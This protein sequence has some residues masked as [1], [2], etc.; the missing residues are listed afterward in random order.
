MGSESTPPRALDRTLF[1]IARLAYA[2]TAPAK[3]MDELVRIV[4]RFFQD[5]PILLALIDAD[6]RALG[7]ERFFHEGNLKTP[8]LTLLE[9]PHLAT[10]V[11]RRNRPA[12]SESPTHQSRII[13]L[14]EDYPSELCIP[15]PHGQQCMGTLSILGSSGQ[16]WSADQIKQG[17]EI[18]KEAA[19]VLSNL[20]KNQKLQIQSLQLEG[21]IGVAKR[22][23]GTLEDNNLASLITR[24]ALTLMRCQ[25]CCLLTLD[26]ERKFLEIRSVE[27][28]HHPYDRN[29]KLPV[30]ESSI[31]IAIQLRKA[32]EVFDIRLTEEHFFWDLL[33]QEN[34]VSMIAVPV[35]WNGK[36]RGVLCAF[37]TRVRRFNN[38][39]KRLFS[40]LATLFGISL[41]NQRLYQRLFEFEEQIR[42]N[43]KLVTLG[44]LAAEIA[45][46]IRNPL[47]VIKLLFDTL[48]LNLQAS[49]EEKKDIRIILEKIHH[50]EEIV[51]RVLSYGKSSE[52]IRA[53]YNLHEILEETLVLMRMKLK[54]NNISVSLSLPEEDQTTRVEASKGQVQQVF[55]NLLINAVDAMPEGGNIHLRMF[56][57]EG[58][59][60]RVTIEMEDEGKGIPEFLQNRIFESFL[61][62]KETGTGLGLAIV[63]R[64]LRAHRGDIELLTSQPGKTRFRFWLPAAG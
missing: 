32:I 44:M 11:S 43:D 10:R 52:S 23:V 38:D 30:A 6:S 17:Q 7:V 46:E 50:L 47:T 53:V 15:L 26:N 3:A 18:A 27:G 14:L 29:R 2:S 40:T 35:I 12:R 62:G 36:A 1:E 61:T 24:E 58:K 9:D 63:K 19:R 54:Q 41:Q 21:L 39:E 57:T 4:S 16:T 33:Q 45:H 20:W 64:I 60:K 51:T 13:P 31:G 25:V 5:A 22:L 42:V 59:Q 28:A 37:T 56:T 8:P 34:L 55:M 49:P 48:T